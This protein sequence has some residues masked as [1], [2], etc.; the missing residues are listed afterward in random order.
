M[1]LIR[2]DKMHLPGKTSPVSF[3]GEVMGK[4]WN[5]EENSTALSHAAILLG[6]RPL[7]ITKR[8]GAQSGALV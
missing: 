5:L 4:G 6:R 1:Q 2:P 8:E 7:I 3:C